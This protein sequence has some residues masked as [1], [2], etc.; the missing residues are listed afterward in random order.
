MLRK[1]IKTKSKKKKLQL[2]KQIDLRLSKKH[3]SCVEIQI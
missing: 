3:K 2:R 1:Q